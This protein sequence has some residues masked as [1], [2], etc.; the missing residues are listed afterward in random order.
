M[1]LLSSSK[2]SNFHPF[3]YSYHKLSRNS[4]IMCVFFL[5]TVCLPSRENSLTWQLS[6]TNTTSSLKYLAEVGQNVIWKTTVK[7][8]KQVLDRAVEHQTVTF[9]GLGTKV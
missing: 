5:K 8:F 1:Q 7:Q 2:N 6:Q 9:E 3:L 4:F